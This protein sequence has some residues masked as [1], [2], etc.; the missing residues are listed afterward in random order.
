LGVFQRWSEG[1]E[2]E[3]MPM[4]ESGIKLGRFKVVL[5]SGTVKK[6]QID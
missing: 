2:K 1:C 6:L 5:F 3:E 4:L